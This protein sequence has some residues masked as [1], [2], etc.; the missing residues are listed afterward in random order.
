MM[1]AAYN[2]NSSIGRSD[3]GE[4]YQERVR[5]YRQQREQARANK[6]RSSARDKYSNI[7]F[8]EALY[9]F[10]N[11]SKAEKILDDAGRYAKDFMKDIGGQHF[12]NHLS[13]YRDDERGIIGGV[14]A[15]IA[16]KMNWQVK[17]VRIATAVS[18][19]I[20]TLPTVITYAAATYFLRNKGLAYRG[21]KNEKE[22][23]RTAGREETKQNSNNAQLDAEFEE[24]KRTETKTKNNSEEN[25]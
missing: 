22:F 18:G 23:W 25:K 12:S 10:K 6:Y 11:K 21:R 19:F 24:L 9:R 20:F 5:Y 14:C 16:D 8:D 7:D 15:G 4:S 17:H 3:M 1:S 13:W 2:N